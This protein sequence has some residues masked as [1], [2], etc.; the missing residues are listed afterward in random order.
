[1]EYMILLNTIAFIIL[2]LT[3]VLYIDTSHKL[4]GCKYD[5]TQLF[6][7]TDLKCSTSNNGDSGNDG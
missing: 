3:T 1:M 5:R 2:M 6:C 7:Y 4:N